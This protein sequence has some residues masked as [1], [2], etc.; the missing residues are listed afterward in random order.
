MEPAKRESFWVIVTA[1]GTLLGGV[2]A[3][4]SLGFTYQGSRGDGKA[5]PSGPPP[6]TKAAPATKPAAT[7]P[8]ATAPAPATQAA[9]QASTPASAT[10]T[11]FSK[12][13]NVIHYRELTRTQG[14]AL[15]FDLFQEGRFKDSEGGQGRWGG[16]STVVHM[17]YDSGPRNISGQIV[18]GCIVDGYY[19]EGTKIAKKFRATCDITT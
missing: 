4:I 2:A 18:K 13:A 15:S 10:S 16:D 8:V 11:A 7:P 17:E 19:F 1:V 14:R 6:A 12:T 3:A 5:S 9:P